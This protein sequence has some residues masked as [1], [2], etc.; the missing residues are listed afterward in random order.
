VFNNL[1]AAAAAAAE[2][3]LWPSPFYRSYFSVIS[4]FAAPCNLC[5]PNA[6]NVALDQSQYIASVSVC[7]S[8]TF[9]PLQLTEL[10]VTTAPYTIF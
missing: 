7:M 2:F 1:A 8:V 3:V 5:G 4:L 6:V 9:Q 10:Q